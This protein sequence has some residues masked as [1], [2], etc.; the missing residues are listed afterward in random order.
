MWYLGSFECIHQV[1]HLQND[2]QTCALCYFIFTYLCRYSLI[3]HHCLNHYV[4]STGGTERVLIS[5]LSYE[6][7]SWVCWF[8]LLLLGFSPSQFMNWSPLFNVVTQ[9]EAVENNAVHVLGQGHQF[10]RLSE[11]YIRRSV[12]HP[13]HIFMHDIGKLIHPYLPGRGRLW[14]SGHPF[15]SLDPLVVRYCCWAGLVAVWG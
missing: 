1:K 13:I 4:V 2:R 12:F 5:G 3:P 10:Y 7:A 6:L 15:V 9:L 14:I 11:L 8:C